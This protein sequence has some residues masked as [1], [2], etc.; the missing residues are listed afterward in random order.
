MWVLPICY[1]NLANV[2]QWN[3]GWPTQVTTSFADSILSNSTA[4]NNTNLSNLLGS[5]PSS[6]GSPDLVAALSGIEDALGKFIGSTDTDE[7]HLT[8]LKALE[9]NVNSR[10]GEG[11]EKRAYM[12]AVSPWFFTHYSPETFNKNVRALPFLP[13]IDII[14]D[15]LCSSYISQ[16]NTSI[17]N[18]GNHSSLRGINLIS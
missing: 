5:T 3:S 8:G 2:Y 10:D 1:T 17:Q 11:Q 16:I 18:A 9:P 7:V 15:F 12:A 14:V 13:F 6:D 4:N